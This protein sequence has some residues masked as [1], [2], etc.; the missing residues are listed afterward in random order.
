MNVFGSSFPTTAMNIRLF[1]LS[2]IIF[3]HLMMIAANI[4]TFSI[5]TSS[6]TTRVEAVGNAESVT[7]E[8]RN[9]HGRVGMMNDV[10]NV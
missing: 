1:D 4:F 6:V 8:S 5:G 9:K 2:L 3:D 10:E 7:A